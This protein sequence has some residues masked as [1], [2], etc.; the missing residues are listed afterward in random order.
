MRTAVLE[1]ARYAVESRVRGMWGV[2]PLWGVEGEDA[3][4]CGDLLGVAHVSGGGGGG[5]CDR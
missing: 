4:E 3:S 2:V 1:V 5:R